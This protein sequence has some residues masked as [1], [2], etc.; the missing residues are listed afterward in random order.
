MAFYHLSTASEPIDL[1]PRLPDNYLVRMGYEN[2]YTPR[3]C[4][5]NSIK[6]C[7]ASIGRNMDLTGKKYF[8]HVVEEYNG[9]IKSN[10]EIR[11]EVPD[12]HITDEVWLMNHATTT[13]IGEVTVKSSI[14]PP[15]IFEYGGKFKYPIKFWEFEEHYYE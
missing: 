7:L 12:A 8:I 9:A 5:S 3:I 10:M 6:G 4:M 11:S 14:E 1:E 13:I 15:L 2:N